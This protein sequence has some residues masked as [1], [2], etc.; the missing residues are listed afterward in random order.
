MLI[1]IQFK[2]WTQKEKLFSLELVIPV[3]MTEVFASHETISKLWDELIKAMLS[4]VDLGARDVL[5]PGML[6]LYG[7]DE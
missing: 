4:H 5:R 6:P 7:N 3:K 2:Q 1:I